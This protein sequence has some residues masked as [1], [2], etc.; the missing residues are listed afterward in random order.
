MRTLLFLFITLTWTNVESQ[1]LSVI[2]DPDGYTNIREGKG[3]NT[4]II[5]RIYE[6]EVFH[7]EGYGNNGEHAGPL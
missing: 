5:G 4:K 1:I 3:T 2:D 6:D 7:H